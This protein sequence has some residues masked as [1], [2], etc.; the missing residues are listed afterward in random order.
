MS[1]SAQSIG[2]SLAILLCFSLLGACSRLGSVED[3]FVSSCQ[4]KDVPKSV[5]KCVYDDV[6]KKYT[7]EQLVEFGSKPESSREYVD[8]LIL[9]TARCMH[10]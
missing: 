7:D 9:A 10:R 3:Q 4:A 6:S 2:G 5:C 1:T 8:Q